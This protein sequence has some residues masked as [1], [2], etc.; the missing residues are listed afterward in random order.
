MVFQRRSVGTRKTYRIIRQAH[1]VEGRERNRE[2][3]E[4]VT[5]VN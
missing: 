1:H 4:C 2:E 5:G 3:E